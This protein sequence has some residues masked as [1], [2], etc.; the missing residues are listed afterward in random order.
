MKRCGKIKEVWND[1]QIVIAARPRETVKILVG[2]V[3]VAF[4]WYLIQL[5]NSLLLRTV[6]KFGEETGR[7][8]PLLLCLFG[9]YCVAR[10]PTI[11]GY[12]ISGCS[13]ERIV[14][15]INQN[16]LKSWLYKDRKKRLEVSGGKVMSLLLND[17]GTIM[18][19]FLFM[20][21][22]INF[23]EPF[24][25]G[26]LSIFVFAMWK[27]VVLIPFLFLGVPSVLLNRFFQKK[28]KEYSVRQRESFDGLTRFFQYLSEE[29]D[30]IKESGIDSLFFDKGKKV[31]KD[32]VKAEKKKEYTLRNARFISDLLE[33]IGLVSGVLVCIFLASQNQVEM[34]DLAFVFA[35]S[36]FV[37]RFFNCFT[38]TW[39][40][41]TD[42]YTSVLRLKELAGEDKKTGLLPVK[43]YE[44]GALCIRHVSFAYPGHPPV[45]ENFSLTLPF[46]EKHVLIGGNGAGKSTLMRI[47]LGD[48]S[49]QEGEIFI[50]YKGK[51]QICPPGFF[52]YIPQEPEL[53]NISFRENMLLDCQ[54]FEKKPG[55]GEIEEISTLLG[56]HKKI[57]SLSEQ[58][59]TIVV[60]N[61]KN[62]SLGEKQKI[63]LARAL[64]SP[65]PC[66]LMDEPEHG[67]D[68]ESAEA[69][70]SYLSKS[71]KTILMISHT[72]EHLAFFDKIQI[73]K[74]GEIL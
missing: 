22:T 48:L 12:R 28:V 63:V 40:Y 16:L 65:A 14:G 7:N 71:K 17:N 5:T 19:D 31:E 4:A 38:N 45:L 33:D 61:G 66:I 34:A 20:G 23:V 37:F 15:T 1:F 46:H 56:L 36:P 64:L 30:T 68:Q 24:L 11:L 60:E 2:S 18:S 55:Q 50:L 9:L 59:D 27:P 3:L 57:M 13:A 35:L 74:S 43:E 58:Y 70:F 10:I 49:P 54:R 25:L 6:A 41:L 47:L 51:K 21:F 29:L 39:N 73:L 67:L 52:T 62:L 26:V 44:D 8:Y 53:L 69:F 32:A 72:K 42:V